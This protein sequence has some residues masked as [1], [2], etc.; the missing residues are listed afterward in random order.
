MQKYE[1]PRMTKKEIMT[2]NFLG[3]VF[4]GLGTTI[5]VSIILAI[6][7]FIATKINLVPYVGN[8]ISDI[9]RYVLKNNPHAR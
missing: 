7:G 1:Q 6:L 4:F 3:G 2:N 9:L 5:G 8:F